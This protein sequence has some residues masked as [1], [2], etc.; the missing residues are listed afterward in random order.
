MPICDLAITSVIQIK[1]IPWKNIFDP[2][3]TVPVILHLIFEAWQKHP[4]IFYTVKL[5]HKVEAQHFLTWRETYFYNNAVSVCV[6]SATWSKLC[7]KDHNENKDNSMFLFTKPINICA[8]YMENVL[9]LDFLRLTSVFN[10]LPVM[11]SG[12][13]WRNMSS[14]IVSYLCKH[15]NC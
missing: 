4:R 2:V 8:V 5:Q 9:L 14:E 7:R 15:H 1:W 10:L 12:V 3:T 13:F 11:F 6:C